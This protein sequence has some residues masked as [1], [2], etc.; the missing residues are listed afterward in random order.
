MK[1]II[2]ADNCQPTDVAAISNKNQIGMEIQSYYDP[3]YEKKNPDSYN[4]H[5]HIL[6]DMSFKAMHGPFGDLCPGSFDE[7]VRN[8]TKMRF[9]SAL[10]IAHQL[11]IKHL[12]LHH[13]CVPRTSSYQ[14]WINRC[15][16][17]WNSI[18]YTIPN[19]FS[20]YLEN[21]LEW[22]GELIKA[23]IDNVGD[24]RLKFNLDIGHAHAYSKKTV[25]QWIELMAKKIGYVHLHNNFGENDEHNGLTK[26]TIPIEEV[27]YALEEKCPDAIWSLEPNLNEIQDSIEWL[28]MHSFWKD[29]REEKKGRENIA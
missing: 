29:A 13:C 15:K 2:I 5:K 25:L 16:D 12:V 11:E 23:V 9:T 20:I 24:N 17:F 21:M 4:F 22:D 19:D 28:Q 3:S 26:G 27:L 14:G 1:T 10:S 6:K 18:L 8:V 7:E